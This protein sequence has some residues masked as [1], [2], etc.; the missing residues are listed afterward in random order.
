MVPT[1]LEDGANNAYSALTSK[2][3]HLLTSQGLQASW[4]WCTSPVDPSGNRDYC[5]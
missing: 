3:P 2:C 1:F 4:Q 5:L